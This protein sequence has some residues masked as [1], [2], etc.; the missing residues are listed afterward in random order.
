MEPKHIDNFIE[1]PIL[2]QSQVGVP[3]ENYIYLYAALQNESLHI[4][5]KRPNG[6]VVWL[7]NHNNSSSP[8]IASSEEI[9]QGLDVEKYIKPNDL[10]IELNKKENKI[11]SSG[12]NEENSENLL[13]INQLDDS[14]QKICNKLNDFILE[15]NIS[16]NEETLK[17]KFLGEQ[18]YKKIFNNFE[19]SNNLLSPTTI[20]SSVN[21]IIDFNLMISAADSS[22]S[23]LLN[24]NIPSLT[25]YP[26]LDSGNFKIY[27]N[28]SLSGA[29]SIFGWVKYIKI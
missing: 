3:R 29:N 28:W 16:T 4:G 7:S 5:V 13:G 1:I 14:V 27:S 19:V 18:V 25:I 12:F 21:K 17:E 11:D 15:N 2:N 26:K 8:E 20:L 6:E 22:D 24:S 23:Y 10:K 9:E